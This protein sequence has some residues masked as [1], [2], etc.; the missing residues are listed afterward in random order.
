MHILSQGSYIAPVLRDGL[1]TL[2]ADNSITGFGYQSFG[3]TDLMGRRSPSVGPSSSTGATTRA[4][5][6]MSTLERS[7]KGGK[8]RGEAA[9][10][11]GA[12]YLV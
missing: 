7:V 5:N 2:S 4:T 11:E 9:F 3:S 12:K 1:P 6:Q 10:G 8:Q